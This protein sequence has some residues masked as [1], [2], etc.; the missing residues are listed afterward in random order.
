M[1][2]LTLMSSAY[3]ARLFSLLMF[4]LASTTSADSA[5]F[6]LNESTNWDGSSGEIVDTL[7]NYS[8]A[9]RIGDAQIIS[10]SDA[11]ACLAGFIPENSNS[12][13]DAIDT[14]VDIDDDIGD[15][16]TIM[17]WY[18]SEDDDENRR[19]FD[20]ST[21]SKYFYLFLDDD[22][23]LEFKLEDSDDEDFTISS[24]D[25]DSEQW[26]H[27]AVTW[28]LD[29]DELVLYINGNQEDNDDIDSNGELGNLSTLYI[30]DN[31]QTS[32]IVGTDNS[33][34]GYFDDIRIIDRALDED[35]IEDYADA[36][37]NCGGSG[38]GDDGDNDADDL[39]QPLAFFELSETAAWSGSSGEIIDSTGNYNNAVQ[40]GDAQIETQADASACLAGYIPSNTDNSQDAIHTYIDIDDNVGNQ[41]S[42][43]FWYKTTSDENNRRLFDA[44]TN[45]KYFYLV[46]DDNDNLEFKLEDDDD[47]DFAV[48]TNSINSYD[49]NHITVTWDFDDET[50]AIYV[51]GVLQDSDS[52]SSSGDIAELNT[53]YF[54]DNR[55]TSNIVG[56]NDSAAG[57]FDDIRIFDTAL[58]SDEVAG[59]AA[60][61]RSCSDTPVI[62]IPPIAA[63][64]LSET[65]DWNGTAGEVID[66]TGNFTSAMQI[67]DA[68]IAND[69]YQEASACLAGYIPNNRNTTQDAIDTGIN[70][71]DDI[72]NKGTI[73]FWY[74]SVA[75]SGDNRLFDASLGNKYFYMAISSDD[76]VDFK[77]EDDADDDYNVTSISGIELQQWNHI[78]VT[79]DLDNDQMEMYINGNLTSRVS[80]NS[81][82]SIADF[83]SLYF[84]DNRLISPIIGTDNSAHGYFDDIYIFDSVLSDENVDEYAS[85]LR[86]CTVSDSTIHH[87]E[88]DRDFYQGLT[89]EPLNVTV[90]ACLDESCSQQTSELIS[91][92]FLPTSGWNGSNTKTEYSSGSSFEFQRTT[93][94]TYSFDISSSSPA[95]D[96]SVSDYLRC[97]VGGIEQSNCQVEF[98]DAGYRF[99]EAASGSSSVS[100]I[101]LIAADTSDTLYLRATQTDESTGQ[102]VNVQ[103]SN[104]EVASEIGTSCSSTDSCVAG[105][106]VIWNQ[107]S[108]IALAN[109]TDQQSGSD[110]SDIDISFGS[111]DTAAFTL[112]A[113]D[114][115]I[116]PLT[117]R[118]E[119]L[120]V[121]GNATGE[122]IEGSVSLRVR[123]A[124][125]VIQQTDV[126]N[127]DFWTAGN[128][129]GVTI[130]G[131]DVN[132][133]ATKSFG[134]I[135]DLYSVDW[136][137]SSV[138]DPVGGSLGAIIGGDSSDDWSSVDLASGTGIS[139]S[140]G[141]TES[142]NAD[143]QYQEVG[144]VNL[145]ATIENYLGSDFDVTSADKLTGPSIPAYLNAEQIDSAIWGS[146][147]DN[148]Y[149][150]QSAELSELSFSVQ[151]YSS[152]GT[153]LTNYVGDYVDF[154]TGLDDALS[155]PDS[156]ALVGGDIE[157]GQLTWQVS[158]DGTLA[159]GDGDGTIT[160]TA[161]NVDLL[162][163]RNIA[164]ASVNDIATDI[165]Q[166]DLLSSALTDAD[167]VCVKNSASET[168]CEALSVQLEPR[169]LYFVRANLPDTV[170]GGYYEADIDITLEALSLDSNGDF[171][172]STLS[173]DNDLASDTF[174]GLDFDSSVHGCTLAS[175]SDSEA[176]C[177]LLAQSAI[178]YGP[179]GTGDYM[180]AGEA[181]FRVYSSDPL[182]G[183]AELQLDA[184]HWL[185]WDWS[186]DAS[187][188]LDYTLDSTV[189]L[190][191]EYQGRPPVLFTRPSYR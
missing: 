22:N 135:N 171:S 140:D 61:T 74:R 19:L 177:L 87:Y 44:S 96:S 187:I 137:G 88:L 124:S 43:M 141:I 13:Q 161:N 83:N 69:S 67:G 23:E 115:G 129:F 179:D 63:F 5:F 111:N 73:L 18:K 172:W 6:Q 105:E 21:D 109:P 90:R 159:E 148:I 53:L 170:A 34:T 32:N 70:I 100:F 3:L 138:A 121:D 185:T 107:S 169:T 114:V 182:T 158:N 30:G 20:A 51:N 4:V 68:Q 41:G 97:F 37:R 113:P 45:S 89:C 142:I 108:D 103:T 183:L 76:I 33:A 17:F 62:L 118:S 184:P 189:I 71:N 152:T 190:F 40:V 78:G 39:T 35:E 15:Q 134:R 28:D 46:M 7:T 136:T 2:Q 132:G 145:V 56:T 85:V 84:G 151:A 52:F 168:D 59:F 38:G 128:D 106:Q 162:W 155:K 104:I 10:D 1:K 29:N 110:Y 86:D 154:N 12:S 127:A 153:L 150:G 146:E 24:D 48:D 191:G 116:Q 58:E 180:S 173:T 175:Q 77:L 160:L 181:L 9:R 42:I 47:D 27:I 31:R 14:G 178:Y 112:T 157:T 144:M 167:G 126:D 94:S 149:Q 16:G 119:I 54:G 66:S 57:Y 8:S 147:D 50:I 91:T 123:P 125:L 60:L 133:N 95:L 72:G 11:S 186:G 65:A 93:A 26:N 164:G 81:S 36:N 99:F 163:P 165:S 130:S 120:D 102:C 166:L 75:N 80:F 64:E 92:S 174:Y 188:E 117:I 101:D 55:T 131:L 49:W 122:Y 82:G 139:G 143:I 98:V 156:Q 25:F 79:W 176:A